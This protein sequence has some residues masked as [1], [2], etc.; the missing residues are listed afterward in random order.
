MDSDNAHG[1]CEKGGAVFA[2]L[3]K[4]GG[5]AGGGT[6]FAGWDIGRYSN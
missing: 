4:E 5:G 1:P 2:E 6:T 3:S